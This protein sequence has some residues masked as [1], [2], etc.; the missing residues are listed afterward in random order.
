MGIG[1]WIQEV[2]R[3]RNNLIGQSLKLKQLE[4][5]NALYEEALSIIAKDREGYDG[6]LAI[7]Y[8]DLARIALG[9]N[10]ELY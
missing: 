6:F 7:K 9:K 3:L 8:R 5:T 4:V 1:E 2:K 10:N